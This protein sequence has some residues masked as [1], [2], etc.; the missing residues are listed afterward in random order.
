MPMLRS[1]LELVEICTKPAG[2]LSCP[3][4]AMGGSR[5]PDVPPEDLAG[6]RSVT[7]GPFKTMLFEGD[8]FC[9]NGARASLLRAL[10]MLGP[11]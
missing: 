6:W 5:D 3:V 8:H 1:D 10:S 11:G 9:L 2:P 7:T 4:V